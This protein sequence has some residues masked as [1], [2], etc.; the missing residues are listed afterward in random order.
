MKLFG[1]RPHEWTRALLGALTGALTGPWWLVAQVNVPAA[2]IIFLAGGAAG[3]YLGRR[4]GR[5]M[6][7]LSNERSWRDWAREGALIGAVTGLAVGAIGG[8]LTAILFS[9]GTGS[10]ELWF[11]QILQRML[12]SW[13]PAVIGGLLLGAGAGVGIGRMYHRRYFDI[14]IL[15]EPD[16]MLTEAEAVPSSPETVPLEEQIIIE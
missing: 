6:G 10:V 4:I 1:S 7:E 16:P 9:G 14:T 8:A 15:H 3:G 11:F 5:N 13:V 12:Q 2:I